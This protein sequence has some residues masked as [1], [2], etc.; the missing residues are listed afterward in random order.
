MF[1]FPG[2]A[3]EMDELIRVM[4]PKCE[5][6]LAKLEGATRAEMQQVCPCMFDFSIRVC[7]KKKNKRNPIIR[8]P[9]KR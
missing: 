3:Q 2:E 1:S 7:P 9:F 4:P 8:E 6:A 5:Q